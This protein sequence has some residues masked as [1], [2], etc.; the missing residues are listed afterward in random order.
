MNSPLLPE[1]NRNITIAG[2][3]NGSAAA[4][5]AAELSGTTTK[6]I[7][8]VTANEG[9][10][11]ET[12]EQ[13]R[14]YLGEDSQE[15]D[16]PLIGS[17]PWVEGS[18]YNE[19]LPERF[20]IEQ[21]MAALS[22][23]LFD[24]QPRIMVA[25]IPSLL[26]RVIPREVFDAFSILV[27]RDT[28]FDREEL[29][30]SL[31]SAGYQPVETVEDPATFAV[32]GQVVDC[33]V[34]M[35]PLPVRLVFFDDI[36]EEMWFFDPQSQKRVRQLDELLIHPAVET[37]L[38][39]PDTLRER[40]YHLADA[41]GYPSSKTRYLLERI[42]LGDEFF[43]METFTPL[44]HQELIPVTD[45][46]PES[47]LVILE[48]PESLK[49]NAIDHFEAERERFEG[50]D[51]E[52]RMV[53]PPQEF[54]LDPNA[55]FQWFHSQQNV[56]LSFSSPTDLSIPCNISSHTTLSLEV[57]RA[58]SDKEEPLAPL[59][60]ALSSFLD[61][62]RAILFV[63][64]E[65]P[66][67]S[68]ILKT[69]GD[70]GFS[71]TLLP[72]GRALFPLELKKGT[73]YGIRGYLRSG[74]TSEDHGLVVLS[75]EELFGR[76]VHR[77]ARQK[78]FADAIESL[79]SIEPGD[80]IVHHEH[81]IGLY[82]GIH[83]MRPAGIPGDYLLI[84]YLGGDKLYLPAHKI[85]LISKYRGGKGE[86]V[87]LDKLGGKSWEKRKLSVSDKVKGLADQLLS[88]ATDRALK[89]GHAYPAEDPLLYEFAAAFPYEETADQMKA[90]EQVYEDMGES[91]PMDRL[92]CGDV[93]YG[94]TEVA[95]RA[96][97]LAVLGGRQVAILAPTTLLVEQHLRTFRERFSSFPVEVAALS[98][99]QSAK[100][101]T[102]V[103]ER[104]SLGTLDVVIGTHRILSRDIHFKNLGLL[105]IDEEQR[106]GVAQKEKL[107]FFK[108][109]LEVLT[110]SATPIPR[111]LHMSIMGIKDISLIT[112]PPQDRLAVKSIVSPMKPELIRE[113]IQHELARGGQIF[114]VVPRITG[115]RGSTRTIA[116]WLE[117]ITD[118][119][120][121][122]NPAMAHGQMDPAILERVMVEFLSGDRKL[123]ISTNIIEAGL[124]IS[125]ANT[126]MIMD[127][128]NF[129]LSQLYQLRGRVGRGKVRAFAYFFVPPSS[130]LTDHA[131]KR[132]QAIQR[133]SQLGAGFNLAS[134]DLE[135]RGAGEMLGT[136]Q[137]GAI[138]AVGFDAYMEIVEEALRE[139]RGEPPL[140]EK[141]PELKIDTTGY[142]PEEFIPEPTERLRYY[143]WFATARDVTHIS[144]LATLLR[145]KYGSL[146]QEAEL[147][148]EL[149]KIKSLLRKIGA[150]GISISL[151]KCL[152]HVGP[153][154][155]ID[156]ERLIDLMQ[157]EGRFAFEGPES[158]VCVLPGEKDHI[159]R[160][161]TVQSH[162]HSLLN[163]VT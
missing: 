62:Q 98:R 161:R 3:G 12:A 93:G 139:L 71:P 74:F 29:A 46:F 11:L 102:S 135:I 58:R 47:I 158:I 118:L 31:V 88:L 83:L 43:G 126:I 73:L 95:L 144:D 112:T 26:R 27:G 54:Y 145:D 14:L 129:G 72:T 23:L 36:I 28:T 52:N 21:R 151:R 106:F 2:L 107:R 81:G 32:R 110:L 79:E 87:K 117:F 69:L 147:Y 121:E 9:R 160:A 94:K 96:A 85:A 125:R 42:Q 49:G 122:S 1:N 35:Y 60:K 115:S 127:A 34:P 141:D 103:K 67:V 57:K 64:P 84:E 136:K 86:T 153:Q 152:I 68:P 25:S 154:T 70:S 91:T 108:P 75:E 162:L 133:Y 33:F 114:V 56:T 10:S 113:A 92:I 50:A 143:R 97:F 13:L 19:I 149:M 111:T 116:E 99:F 63:V 131:K 146:P 41:A 109:N 65:E 120:P 124:D 39:E 119:V 48:D 132:L 6:S 8:Y 66:V 7:L 4:F 140:P 17:L 138:A 77:E 101:Q 59:K 163:C 159:E 22:H 89:E 123:L 40:L 150:E 51:S 156:P 37:I 142:F 5:L 61:E 24:S 15:M 137:S 38:S 130:Q 80:Y 55:L 155:A 18:V 78:K 148:V 157:R 20:S 45:Y 30:R 90:I 104:L 128:Q 44:Y 76:K 53:F 16:R 82:G 134:E 100:N 105:I